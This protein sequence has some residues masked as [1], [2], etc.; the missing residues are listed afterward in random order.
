[1][2]LYMPGG[3]C[4]H[5]DMCPCAQLG[6][7][8]GRSSLRLRCTA[9]HRGMCGYCSG[10]ASSSRDRAGCPAGQDVAV[11]WGG[12][13]AVHRWDDVCKERVCVHHWSGVQ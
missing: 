7:R 6:H 13:G 1:M 3:A 12:N 5:M 11:A 2:D 8:L 10:E 4:V 9:E